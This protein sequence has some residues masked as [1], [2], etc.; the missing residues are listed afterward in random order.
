MLS[1]HTTS[2]IFLTGQK[3]GAKGTVHPKNH[4]FHILSMDGYP[5]VP[6][7][8]MGG[9]MHR[10]R[11]IVIPPAACSP[12][13]CCTPFVLIAQDQITNKTTK[14]KRT[15]RIAITY[16]C[17]PV[18][19]LLS[20][21]SSLVPIKPKSYTKK[22]KKRLP[23]LHLIFEENPVHFNFPGRALIDVEINTSRLV[24]I[25]S[26]VSDGLNEVPHLIHTP[27]LLVQLPQ[28]RGHAG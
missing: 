22:K 8:V 23:L 10:E 1:R 19:M 7:M 3:I 17:T 11:K 9:W 25:G 16:E 26:G 21:C 28:V 12:G 27:I 6:Q 2:S 13:H 5:A 24:V 18:Y 15:N 14:H 4:F 20:H